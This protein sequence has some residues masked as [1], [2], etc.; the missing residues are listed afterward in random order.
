MKKNFIY[1]SFFSLLIAFLL[2]SCTTQKERKNVNKNIP[3]INQNT[4]SIW[5]N[6]KNYTYEQK[7]LFKTDVENAKK[8][9]N[10]KIN[11]LRKKASVSWGNVKENYNDGIEK[12][13]VERGLL[14]KKMSDFNS[15]TK[16]NWNDFK[17]GVNSAW[18]D[19]EKTWEKT[20]EN[21]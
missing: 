17:S 15:I 19:I 1:I 13:V 21:G 6:S 18:S 14:N 2:I 12:L 5:R 16:E 20:N 9:L 7:E 3:A 11:E 4:S 8:K 10:D